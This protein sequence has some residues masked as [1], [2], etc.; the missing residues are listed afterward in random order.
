MT[1]H[2]H[3]SRPPSDWAGTDLGPFCQRVRVESLFLE[4]TAFP[5]RGYEM[6]VCC[7]R[8]PE[9]PRKGKTGKHR[10]EYFFKNKNTQTYPKK[11]LP[12][13]FKPVTHVFYTWNVSGIRPNVTACG[14]ECVHLPT[15]LFVSNL[16]APTS[17]VP[18]CQIIH[19]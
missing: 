12:V 11:P 18:S 17:R 16:L 5:D 7:S 6:L 14:H 1:H 15:A 4:D 3:I 13:L 2:C 9:H 8:V 19:I 10:K